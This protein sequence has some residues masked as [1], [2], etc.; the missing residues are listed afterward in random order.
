MLDFINSIKKDEA[1][2]PFRKMLLHKPLLKFLY[3]ETMCMYMHSGESRYIVNDDDEIIGG[4]EVYCATEEEMYHPK[5]AKPFLVK[6]VWMKLTDGKYFTN[7]K[8]IEKCPLIRKN[9]TGELEILYLIHP[10]S[11]EKHKKLLLK[12]K[13]F[14]TISAIALSSFRSCLIAIPSEGDYKAVMVKLSLD[15]VIGNVNRVVKKR[16]CE[17]SIANSEIL[18]G[19]I[20]KE[21]LSIEIMKETFSF[22]PRG[23]E[24]GMI[25]RELPKYIRPDYKKKARY[26]V[27][28]FSLFGVKNADFLPELIAVSGKTPTEFI[29]DDILKPLAKIITTLLYKYNTSLEMHGQ[30]LLLVMDKSNKIIGFMYRDMGGVNLLPPKNSKY[31]EEIFYMK[32]HKKDSI[33][34]LEMHL[35]FRLLGNITKQFVKNPKI[36]EKDAVFK[37]WKDIFERNNYISNWTLGNDNDDFHET[38]QTLSTFHRYGYVEFYFAI[39]FLDSLLEMKIITHKDYDMFL[40]RLLKN[41][42]TS[43]MITYAPSTYYPFFEFLLNKTYP[44]R[45]KMYRVKS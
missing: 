3:S 42:Q 31:N 34:T 2:A 38:H 36:R 13:N 32:N 23:M 41:E 16:E 15:K 8:N 9:S 18:S 40:S 26:V 44:I 7:L 5:K 21:N 33:S 6:G 12:Y 45:K 10:S 20:K 27:P 1:F 24:I 25:Y 30:N 29:K 19:I 35:N 28:F 11:E 17:L 37:I 39:Y 14:I 4:V 22:I 43:D